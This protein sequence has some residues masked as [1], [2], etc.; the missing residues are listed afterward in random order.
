MSGCGGRLPCCCVEGSETFWGVEPN[1]A[2]EWQARALELRQGIDGGL[3]TRGV[4]SKS[5]M[6][7]GKGRRPSHEKHNSSAFF[8]PYPNGEQHCKDIKCVPMEPE[9]C[10]SMKKENCATLKL[11]ILADFT[12]E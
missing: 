2:L 7:T 11:K 1:A 4:C 9:K 3:S 8:H 10:A 6:F 5:R 12:D